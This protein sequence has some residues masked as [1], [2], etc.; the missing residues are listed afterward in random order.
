MYDWNVN[1]NVE[2]NIKVG[3]YIWLLFNVMPVRC[4]FILAFIFKIYLASYIFQ[5]YIWPFS[6]P[7]FYSPK[8]YFLAY[9]RPL[10]KKNSIRPLLEFVVIL[11]ES[12]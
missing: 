3:S 12:S 2:F 10:K 4:T 11:Q 6:V 8:F 5:F 7:H 1:K 9:K